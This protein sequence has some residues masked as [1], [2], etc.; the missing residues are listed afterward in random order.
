M[1]YSS[2]VVVWLLFLG[3]LLREL[4][5]KKGLKRM[6]G[7][8][9]QGTEFPHDDRATSRKIGRR[10]LRRFGWVDIRGRVEGGKGMDGWIG[11]RVPVFS[12]WRDA[13]LSC[14]L[15]SAYANG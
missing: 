2:R 12:S 14:L 15:P 1:G 5:S 9:Q 7:K 3:P 4:K 10:R 8:Q 11:G 6:N 13:I